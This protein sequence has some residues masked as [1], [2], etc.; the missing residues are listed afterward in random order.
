MFDL[1][2]QYVAERTALGNFAEQSRT[3]EVVRSVLRTFVTHVGED[4]LP[5]DVT[6]RHVE[7]WLMRP[8]FKT[9][10]SRRT[11]L[12]KLKRYGEW[13]V[14]IEE[15][16]RNF[17]AGV[18]VRAEKVARLPRFL[19]VD[20]V[21]NVVSFA[22]TQRDRLV[23]L[24]AV[25]MGLRR[26]EIQAIL[27]EDIDFGNRGLHVRGKGGRGERTRYVPIP[28]ECWNA[29]TALFAMEP[30][31]RGPLILS[32][33]T[34]EALS[35]DR[36]TRLTRRAMYEA[37][38]KQAPYDGKSLHAFRH[39]CGQHLIDAGHPIRQVQG[40]LGHSTQTTTEIYIRRTEDITRDVI[41]GRSYA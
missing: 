23:M 37:G 13:L 20:E 14:S 25:H 24:L 7:T 4:K 27:I 19:E 15:L 6:R 26:E 40:V 29:L 2:D 21:R 36:L 9:Q 39:T 32:T 5:R 10:N 34:G 35:L 11:S 1:V 18:E 3:P 30:R 16:D 31:T 41:D 12:S 33:Q 17:C 38:V 22:K 28:S 8:V